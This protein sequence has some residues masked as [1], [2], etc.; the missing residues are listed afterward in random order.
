MD[1]KKKAEIVIKGLKKLYPNPICHLDFSNAFE[2]TISTI[3]A[4]QCTDV[5]VNMVMGPIYKTKYKT[6]K[7]ILNDGYDN[8]RENIK[9]IT[10]PNNK[11]K[12][13]MALVEILDNK[14]NGKIPDTM[15]ELT[16]LPGL[17]RKSANVILG[18][19]FG[20]KDCIVVDTH[21]KRVTNRLGL[22]KFDEPE[23]IE[24]DLKKIIP[25]KEQFYFS[26][27][28][29]D[30]GRQICDARKPKC[31]KCEFLKICS[32]ANSKK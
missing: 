31:D 11:A 4:A 26:M 29:G 3:L 32:F 27:R 20:K 1:R 12:S 10:F 22:T 9:S 13:I 14:Y 16:K 23:K 28:V 2:L 7:D 8:L 15:E 17:G 19:I 6:P 25:E 18:N 30:H 24:F 5:R 21:F